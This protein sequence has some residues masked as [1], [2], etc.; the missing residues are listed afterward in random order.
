MYVV[1]M[2]LISVLIASSLFHKL[3]Y[4]I[5][6]PFLFPLIPLTSLQMSFSVLRSTSFRLFHFSPLPC[7]TFISFCSSFLKHKNSSSGLLIL[8]MARRYLSHTQLKS[9]L[10]SE[11]IS[12]PGY[13]FG[14]MLLIL[15]LLFSSRKV[16][17]NWVYWLETSKYRIT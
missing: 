3:E 15:N 7:L 9:G 4:R 6:H 16:G 5:S 2:L 14:E 8:G 11:D 10:W 12:A 17:G 13:V 1:I